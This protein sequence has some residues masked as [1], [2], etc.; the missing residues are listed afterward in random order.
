MTR[1]I[2]KKHRNP[3]ALFGQD[4]QARPKISVLLDIGKGDGIFCIFIFHSLKRFAQYRQKVIYAHRIS[5]T[6]TL[7]F[8]GPKIAILR[9]QN[10]NARFF[11][12]SHGRFPTLL[13]KP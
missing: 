3:R 4:G 9:S 1:M 11:T 7:Y 5:R 13:F 8:Y 2:N 12:P 6:Y 10:I